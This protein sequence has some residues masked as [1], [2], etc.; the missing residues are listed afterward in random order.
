MKGSFFVS[1]CYLLPCK[2]KKENKQFHFIAIFYPM[3]TFLDCITRYLKYIFE[4][5]TNMNIKM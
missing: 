1:K 3:R 4:N 5:T 2:V